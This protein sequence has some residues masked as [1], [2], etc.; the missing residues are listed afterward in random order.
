[1]AEN[2]GLAEPWWASYKGQGEDPGPFMAASDGPTEAPQPRTAPG[3]SPT[4]PR[5]EEPDE[6]P[7][8]PDGTATQH[9]GMETYPN[10]A[11]RG[12]KRMASG[13]PGPRRHS[14]RPRAG[15]VASQAPPVT[16]REITAPPEDRT[17][18]SRE[19]IDPAPQWAG[20]DDDED[21]G[22]FS[23]G[24]SEDSEDEAPPP[25]QRGRGGGR[26]TRQPTPPRA[27]GGGNRC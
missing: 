2:S 26:R 22:L 25:P 13:P 12:E 18:P 5:H 23:P 16:E 21:H 14:S 15:L 6:A 10:D 24:Y 17:E 27:R 11:E 4:E 8:E 3:L 20:H 9:V 7:P 19:T 1:M